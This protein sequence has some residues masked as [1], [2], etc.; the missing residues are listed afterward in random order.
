MKIYIA[1]VI[2]CTLAACYLIQRLDQMNVS[3]KV[4]LMVISAY[5]LLGPICNLILKAI[6]R[7][8][9]G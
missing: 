7:F 8:F 1:Y 9:R 3:N 6:V 5:I 4:V 2:I